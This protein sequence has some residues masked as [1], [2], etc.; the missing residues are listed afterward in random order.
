[1]RLR[2]FLIPAF[3]AV[4]VTLAG[5]AIGVYQGPLGTPSFLPS[6]A[7]E[8]LW[9]ATAMPN[10]LSSRANE[11]GV[12]KWT[13]EATFVGQSMWAEERTL[14]LGPQAAG[15]RFLD[16]GEGIDVWRFRVGWPFRW[17]EMSTWSRSGSRTFFDRGVWATRALPTMLPGIPVGI[18]WLPLLGDLG[19]FGAASWLALVW[20]LELRRRRRIERGECAAC[21]HTL[22]GAAICPECGAAGAQLQL[23]SRIDRSAASTSQS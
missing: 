1:M 2:P 22:A 3:V 23:P 9:V 17:A 16:P 11:I 10:E 20:P 8:E 18:R 15:G 6:S 13:Q 21:G 14:T 12:T 5:A 4:A 19:I 7:L